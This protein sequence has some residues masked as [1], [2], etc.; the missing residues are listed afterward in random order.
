MS[1][2]RY[3][4][5]CANSIFDLAANELIVSLR[6]DIRAQDSIVTEITSTR[7]ELIAA[8]QLNERLTVEKKQAHGLLHDAQNEIKALQA[9]LAATRASSSAIQSTEVL[10]KVPG[11]AV[12][13]SHASTRTLLVGSAEAAK[14]AQK[15]ILK[16]ELYGDLTGLI[17]RDVKRKE[18]EGEDV[19]D[20]IQTGRNGSEFLSFMLQL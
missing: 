14:D 8:N 1:I 17:V 19:Y 6:S 9:K 3:A 18:A 13:P 10:P 11:S 20:C 4:R 16:E 2:G 7:K 15:R 5:C 12:K